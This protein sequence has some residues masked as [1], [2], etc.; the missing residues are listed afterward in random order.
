MKSETTKDQLKKLLQQALKELGLSLDAIDITVPE[1]KFGDYSTNAAL[2]LAKKEKKSPK[3]IAE[4]ISVK[5]KE[6]D[7]QQIFSEISPT[8]G[9][10]NFTLSPD[11][12]F[13][14]MQAI[15]DQRDLYGSS[16][17]GGGKTVLVEY[18]ANNVAKPPHVGHLRSAVIGDS[19]LRILRSQ[20]FK[21]ISDTH[22]GDWGT[23]FG[24]LIAGYKALGKKEDVE[25][26]PINELNRLYIEMNQRIEK[27]P[28]LLEKG[29]EEFAKLEK[30]DTENRELWQWFVR[31][32]L[33]D[34]EK[35]RKLL[36]ILPFDHNLGESFYEDKMPSVIADLKNKHLLMESEGAQIVNLEDKKL[37]VG[38]IVKSDG[39]TTYLLRDLAAVK[40]RTKDLKLALMLYVVDNRQAHHLEQFV[41]I[42]ER[43]G[44]IKT[45]DT[46]KHIDFGFMSLPEEGAISSRKGAVVS[47]QH[48]IDEAEKR[49]LN[50][51]NE[52]NP[53]LQNKEAIAKEVALAAIK[54]FDLSHNRK[55]EI[56]FTW[57]K[58]LSFEGNTGPY[59]QYTHARIY[60]IIRKFQITNSKLQINSKNQ[61]SNDL[62][63]HELSVLRK[64][65]QF[66]EIVEQVANDYYPN[67]LCN[68]L[69]EL[70]QTFNSFYQAVP[71]TQEEDEKKK[72]FRLSLITATAQVIKNG[73]YLLGIE[74]PEEM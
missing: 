1:P 27:E 58:A 39:A 51:I 53:D 55:S 62:N 26:D 48:L 18:F 42:S 63:Q 57:E 65:H 29:K 34:F 69:F 71:V 74:A 4:I 35:Y 68:Y 12:L 30:G 20:G 33:E 52:K 43:L 5:V 36:H 32:S 40:Y 46:V 16:I 50:I 3:E 8:G 56:V 19:L 54:Y 59:L 49:A 10:A 45:A 60:G 38:V 21:A 41:E 67:N 15:L 24:I 66:P 37:G 23:Q 28:A 17:M 61:I 7:K 2:V 11:H 72:S 6:L 25:K 9:F 22:I 14:T 47:L 13:K 44:Y 31:V 73:L 64:L 70:S